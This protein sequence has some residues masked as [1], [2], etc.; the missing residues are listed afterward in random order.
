METED[1]KY[2]TVFMEALQEKKTIVGFLE[3]V[4]NFLA[5][6]TDFY[7][8]AKNESEGLGFPPGV[9][10][11]I[12]QQVLFNCDPK[13]VTAIS[14]IPEQH[15]EVAKRGNPPSLA[16]SPVEEAEIVTSPCEVAV[17]TVVE[18]T[19]FEF[20]P[21]S[22]SEN[23]ANNKSKPA[24]LS[25]QQNEYYNGACYDNYCWSQTITEIEVYVL[26]PGHISSSK[27][28][29]IKIE[30]DYVS[31]EDKVKP[32]QKIL[33]GKLSLKCRSSSAVWSISNKKLQITLDKL[34]EVWWDRFLDT[35]PKLNLSKMDCSRPL[36]E[37]PEESQAAIEKIRWDQQQKALGL[38]TSEDL[39]NRELLKKAWDAEGSPFKGTAFDPSLV[40]FN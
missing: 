38:H 33:N 17:E 30:S 12:V 19:P 13:H 11:K 31:I 8:E 10:E 7:Y 24:T 14:R 20:P 9:K 1:F 37:L 28:L 40:K 29:N 27:Q 25:F 5:R 26:L 22:A 36:E 21:Q 2:D 16:C 3:L 4:F 15:G 32:E 6:R 35:E 39:K 34:K 18:T 23:K